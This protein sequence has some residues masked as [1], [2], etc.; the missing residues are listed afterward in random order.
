MN[1][2]QFLELANKYKSEGKIDLSI[3]MLRESGRTASPV[4]F[5]PA[6]LNLHEIMMRKGDLNEALLALVNFMN[7]P[8]LPSTMDVIPKVKQEIEN[9]TRQLNPTPQNVPK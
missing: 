3:E 6:Y 7:C 8:V 9:L 5:G 4:G 1:A 2:F